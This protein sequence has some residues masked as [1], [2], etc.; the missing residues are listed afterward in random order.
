MKKLLI[1]L[2]F[3]LPFSVHAQGMIVMLSLDLKNNNEIDAKYFRD[4]TLPENLKSN[5]N[6]QYGYHTTIGY[7]NNVP[8]DEHA[9]LREVIEEN[10]KKQINFPV[11]FD[12]GASAILGREKL[13]VVLLPENPGI[14]Q[15][16]NKLLV[17][18]LKNYKNGK[19]KLVRYSQTKS[20]IP[21]ISLAAKVHENIKV[22]EL[23]TLLKKLNERLNGVKFEF[24]EFI[25]R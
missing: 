10:L 2:I 20:F 6:H 19:Y 9:A 23:P 12:Y 7:I 22:E 16:Y 4:L 14:F 1:L 17:E 8:E 3:A 13:F 21:H 11:T 25:V 24:T 18:T 15:Q 5:D